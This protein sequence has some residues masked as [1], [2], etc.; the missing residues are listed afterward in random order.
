MECVC[1]GILS[2][3]LYFCLCVCLQQSPRK[4]ERETVCIERERERER[5]EG[6]F[7]GGDMPNFIPTSI[8]LA[9]SSSSSSLTGPLLISSPSFSL[10]HYSPFLFL[11]PSAFIKGFFI[12]LFLFFFF[13]LFSLSLLFTSCAC[14]HFLLV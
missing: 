9:S 7:K 11:F 13:F 6:G 5:C 1:I 12:F 8:F 10:L 4:I 14:P 3:C 2:I